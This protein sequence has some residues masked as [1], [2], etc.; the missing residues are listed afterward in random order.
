LMVLSTAPLIGTP[1]CISYMAGTF[2]NS[3]DT[4]SELTDRLPG[5]FWRLVCEA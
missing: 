1:K 3:T 4:Y 2:G 5:Q